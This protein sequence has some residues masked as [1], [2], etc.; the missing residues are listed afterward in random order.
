VQVEDSGQGIEV[1][2]MEHLFE[3]FEQTRSGRQTGQ[4]TGLGLAISRQFARQM[5]G[6][7]ALVKEAD[8]GAAFELTFPRTKC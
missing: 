8:K 1:H 5:G 2:E 3:A 7:L 6:D 4:G